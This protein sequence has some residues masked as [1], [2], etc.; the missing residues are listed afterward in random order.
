M[1]GSVAEDGGFQV[2][3][4]PSNTISL[5]IKAFGGVGIV[6]AFTSGEN[7]TTN[8]QDVSLTA[9]ICSTPAASS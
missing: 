8:Q 9:N 6:F 5:A 4:K 7:P 2:N 1:S 3:V